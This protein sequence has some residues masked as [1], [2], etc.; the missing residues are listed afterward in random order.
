MPDESK[1]ALNCPY[2]EE[3]IY[4]PLD[5]FKQANSVCPACDKGLTAEQFAAVVADLEQAIDTNIDEMVSEQPKT[6]CCG[7]KSSCCH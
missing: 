7:K 4:E 3:S 1:I 6:S 2:C 5:W